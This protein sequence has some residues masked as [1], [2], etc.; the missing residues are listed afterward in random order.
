MVNYKTEDIRVKKLAFRKEAQERIVA[1]KFSLS[2]FFLCVFSILGQIGLI[3]SSLGKLPPMI[4]LYYSR[5]WGE[6]MLA[7]TYTIWILPILAATFFVLN[8]FIAFFLVKDNPFLLKVLVTFALV[9]C[10]ASLYDVF[11]IM[12]LLV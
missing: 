3:L 9:A 10:L 4:P 6:K 12:S 7:A 1:D 2:V 8:F 5:P 11:K